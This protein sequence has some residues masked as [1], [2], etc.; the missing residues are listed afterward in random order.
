MGGTSLC[1]PVAIPA[2][3]ERR[4]GTL[5]VLLVAAS[6]VASCASP[7]PSASPV[8][9][10]TATPAASGSASPGVTPLPTSTPVPANWTALDLP[11][12]PEVA[13][14]TATEAG[15]AGV[16]PGTGFTLTSLDGTPPRS[17]AARLVVTP[18]V[19]L[20]VVAAT[21][22]TASLRPA[23]KLDEGRVYRF[24]LRRADGT[25]RAAWA[26]QAA[27]ELFVSSTVPG[28][29]TTGVPRDTG[30]E[31]TFD[32]AGVRL[33]D[34]TSRFSISPSVRGRFEQRGRTVAFIPTTP[35]AAATL[36]TVTL[37]HGVPLPGTGMTLARDV[38]VHF[39]T[40][41]QAVSRVHVTMRS[42][43]FD[44]GTQERAVLQVM[45]FRPD[46]VTEKVSTLAVKVHRLA[47]LSAATA[48]YDRVRS[49]PDWMQLSSTLPV[50][51]ASLPLVLEGTVPLQAFSWDA[52]WTNWFQLPKVLPAGWYI[53][54][55]T[56]TGVSRQA[57]LQVT[58]LAAFAI[59]SRTR[60]AV[61]V[62]DLVTDRPVAG[63]T[64][65]LGSAALGTT[66][67]DGLATGASASSV[68]T[69]IQQN[70][71]TVAIVRS[72][73]RAV[74]VPLNPQGWWDGEGGDWWHLLSTDRGR[75]RVSDTVNVW[76]VFRDRNTGS[77]P[78]SVTVRLTPNDYPTAQPAVATITVTPDASGA[79]LTALPFTNLPPGDYLVEGLVGGEP[80][81]SAWITVG[82]IAK[83]AWQIE[84]ATP[85]VAVLT[86]TTVPLSAVATF[87]E[88][89]PVAG[90]ALRLTGTTDEGGEPGTI[91]TTDADGKAAG[92]VPVRIDPGT[93]EQWSQAWLSARGNEPEEG[94]VSRD[95]QV[96]VFRSTAVVDASASVAGTTL[97][98]TGAVHDV[99][100]DRYDQPGADPWA[101]DPRGA[102]RAGAKVSL[103]VVDV[104]PIVKQAGTTYD[105]VTKRVVPRYT[106]TERKVVLG[107][108]VATT[109][110]DGR[111]ART[112][113]VAG[114]DR[115]Y[116]VHATY[117]DETSRS[118]SAD[119]AAWQAL[120]GAEVPAARLE[121]VG[122]DPE[123]PEYGVGETV[124]LTFAGGVEKPPVARY[125]FA[126]SARGL[127][128]VTVQDGPQVSFPFTSALVPSATATVARF[129]GTGYEVA[130]HGYEARFREADRNVVVE[131]T[132]DQARYAPGGRATV[133][134]RTLDA[135]G[136]PVAASV[137]LRAIDE[138]LFAMRA[139]WVVD[140]LSELYES[141]G[142]G[143]L[144]SGW[145]HQN[146]DP[147]SQGG[148]VGG[149]NGGRDDF[150]DWLFARLV[151]TGSDGRASIAFDLS[152]DLTSWR[153]LASAVTPDLEAGDG[154]V[155]VSVG[156]PFF[157]DVVTAAEYL[158]AD[159]PV[160]RVRA[161]GSGLSAGDAVT[162]RV[163][164]DT[165]P[166]SMATLQGRAFTAVEVALPA[167]RAGTHRVRVEASTGSG[168]T[169]R[170]DTIT[171]TFTVVDTRA[172]RTH[173]TTVPL[174]AGTTVGG[175]TGLT[176]V[177]LV[178][179]G[180]GR[181][182]PFLRE[183][184]SSDPFRADRAI[185]AAMARDLLATQFGIPD[186]PALP[187]VDLQQFQQERGIAVLPYASTD[188]ELTAM[189]ALSG[190]RHLDRVR[191]AQAL[192]DTGDPQTTDSEL[193]LLVG[194]AALGIASVGDVTQAA[195]R[196]D[197][198]WR[199][200]AQVALAAVAVGD[201]ALARTI[202]RELLA[203]Y[204]Q[205]SGTWV[206]L[207]VGTP[208]DTAVWT[209]RL[210]IVAAAIGDPLA[211]DMDAEVAAHPPT[212]TLVD[213]ERAI[214]ASYWVR[215]QPKVT[216]VAAITLDGRRSE[217][218][219]T[220]DQPARLQVTPAQRAGLR[221]DPVSGSVLVL[222]TWDGPV[223]AGDLTPPAGQS[224][225][226]SVQP[227][228]VIGAT[229]T[230]VVTLKV[231]LGPSA[232]DGCWRVTDLV[233]SGLVA[234]DAP[235]RWVEEGSPLAYLTP[236]RVLGQRVDFCVT[237]N[238]KNPTRTLRYL[239]RVITPG[240]Y[241]WEPA[242]LQSPI[243]PEQ[244]IVLP[245]FDVTIKGLGS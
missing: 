23:T 213:L 229:Q 168:A 134:V 155:L 192:S 178:D 40:T 219:I 167:L 26:V 44:A 200:R 153:V 226:R 21:A 243:V 37:R 52:D 117:V 126:V 242:V 17:L 11:A 59:V 61:W 13:R 128:T 217:V 238:P 131:L 145:S 9:A 78:R 43:L 191:L 230:V 66:N 5:T 231:T 1:R 45:L 218:T 4:A 151:T 75:Y 111:F 87:F 164:S 115:S 34:V 8:V 35:L 67:A 86:G 76:G 110:A 220:A 193:W 113:A 102:P 124:R 232:D 10:P 144:A 180:R 198:G 65:A 196:A 83:P 106:V 18:A 90:A 22:T 181:V 189:A 70:D 158:A 121:A 172:V 108:Y 80:I 207:N 51:T 58:D 50:R 237:R 148:D 185:A 138:K 175:G 201:L 107:T 95:L 122:I 104:T 54:T 46:G 91:V 81:A 98:L 141:P 142:S 160:I 179:A 240:T 123:H 157:A 19:K 221:I 173:A 212:A 215:W 197:L 188:L 82:P 112:L 203:K 7:A 244:G 32:Q 68:V 33:A 166:M 88:G 245:A 72:G 109:G 27:H 169:R 149:G 53:V 14:L 31:I 79:V 60:T 223:A 47:G 77:V 42:P 133:A 159:R 204:G 209:A 205:R 170:V 183:L 89:T 71:A 6:L 55:A 69:A 208:E 84:L 15:P 120:P 186:D 137:Y 222:A 64:V 41:G 48:A 241:R 94:D 233:P 187:A 225:T 190:D 227:A 97:T 132:P 36:Y 29:N 235:G 28:D 176:T 119:A 211:A 63:A 194:R 182:V 184:A 130:I 85:K 39:E 16:S 171:R 125:L 30:I 100:F 163:S 140:A 161:Y 20:T 96:V 12:L 103:Q 206:R 239:A 143:L 136:H 156:L 105:F 129:T 146:P 114:G 93:S 57:V 56:H 101:V 118:T 228:G 3:A 24:E 38:V 2:H 210:A 25:T 154:S 147:G 214:A 139:A 216:A 152:D 135:T 73:S 236:W 150:R 116:E 224:I 162:F 62:N 195:A 49:A 92:T 177:T 74:F 202:E 199:Q 234:V 174:V 99:A 165:L 127:R